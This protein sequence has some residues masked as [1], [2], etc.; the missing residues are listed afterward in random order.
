[1]F[2]RERA[3]EEAGERLFPIRQGQGYVTQGQPRKHHRPFT[4]MTCSALVCIILL[5]HHQTFVWIC[6]SIA[7][8][9]YIAHMAIAK[10]SNTALS[11]PAAVLW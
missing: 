1:M 9:C 4:G 8:S 7:N 10:S 11:F 5:D 6:L 2:E 3:K